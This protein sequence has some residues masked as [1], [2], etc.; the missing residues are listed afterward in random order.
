MTAQ[1][2]FAERLLEYTSEGIK[3]QNLASDDWVKKSLQTI[4]DGIMAANAKQMVLERRRK[5]RDPKLVTLMVQL[6]QLRT[7]LADAAKRLLADTRMPAAASAEGA[8]LGLAK[9]T[10][11]RAKWDPSTWK[12]VV[13]NR[14][15]KRHEQRMSEAREDG[16]YLRIWKWT[17]VW[18]DFQVC[19]AE[20]VEGELRLVYYTLK[21]LH[22][23]PPWKTT[24]TWYVRGRIVGRR[25]LPENVDE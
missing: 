10:V 22:V 24:K 13:I 17:E 6:R 16:R 14:G 8:L 3:E 5:E 12:R 7:K 19:A 21:Y 11:K 15:K 1:V 25:I 2:G 18:E 20:E 23:G 9:S 4:D